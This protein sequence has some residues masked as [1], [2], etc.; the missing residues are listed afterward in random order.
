M[1]AD[2]VRE[3]DPTGLALVCDQLDMTVWDMGDGRIVRSSDRMTTFEQALRSFNLYEAA[4]RVTGVTPRPYEVVHVGQ[5]YGVMVEYVRGLSLGLHLC[6][7]SYSPVEAGELIGDIALRLH[8]IELREGYD[9]RALFIGM[10]RCV[11]PHLPAQHAEQLVELVR[12]IPP[13]NTLLHGDL[14][15]GNVI[16]NRSG[17]HLIDMDTI[18]FG[19]PVLDLAITEAYLYFG[20]AQKVAELN[21]TVETATRSADA[22]WD[23]VLRRYFMGRSEDEL[24]R[25]AQRVEILAQLTRCCGGP[26]YF[27]EDKAATERWI[28]RQIEAFDGLLA[29]TLPQVERLDF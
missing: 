28:M 11:A 19:H 17:A 27:E 25:I 10:A 5:R 21:I 3:F 4:F 9:M 12:S 20:I 1:T 16:I 18:S 6:V 22:M 7:G 23:A 2:D 8:G 15:A 14:H 13:R 29:N 26:M 24:A